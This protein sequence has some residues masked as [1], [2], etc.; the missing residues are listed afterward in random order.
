MFKLYAAYLPFL[1]N[2]FKDEMSG[3]QDFLEYMAVYDVVFM[4]DHPAYSFPSLAPPNTFY[5]GAF[6]LQDRPVLPLPD[7]YM[8]FLENCPNKHVVYMS[9]GSYLKD[10]TKFQKSESMIRAIKNMDVCVV[11]K[12]ETDIAR[13]FD[14]PKNRV[15]TQSW[16][17]QKDLL[18]S[19]KVDLFISH[20]GNNGRLESLYYNVPLLCVPLFM[21]Q[22]HNARLIRRNGFGGYI[23][24]ED[25]TEDTFRTT[26]EESLENLPVHKEK[27]RKA[28]D[29]VVNDP[30]AGIST[31][32]FYSDL[33]IREAGHA[34]FLINKMIMKQS[35]FEI[36][37]LD[38]ILVA[39][40][41]IT[42]LV[43]WLMICACRILK[44]SYR[45]ICGL[46]KFKTE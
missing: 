38:I 39:F 17:P 15:L 25:L 37:N 45:K 28:T 22:L 2:H 33:L 16:I 35:S 13:E 26:A 44:F 42:F 32:K 19:G 11:M 41:G 40:L 1:L 23:L 36:Y 12:S 31:L 29:I 7:I 6:H 27:I 9:F 34:E 10:L 43:V 4:L 46:G 18:G 14:L 30:G 3:S 8:N 20:C 24:K 21:D 5:L